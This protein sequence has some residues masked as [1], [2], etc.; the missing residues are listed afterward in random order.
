MVCAITDRRFGRV[1]R[2]GTR[3]GRMRM[4]S[5]DPVRKSLRVC[6][7]GMDAGCR[8]SRGEQL[9]MGGGKGL[10]QG[11]VRASVL[12]LGRSGRRRVQGELGNR[13]NARAPTDGE[14]QSVG[15]DWRARLESASLSK[16]GPKSFSLTV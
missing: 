10:Q 13:S 2:G 8:T 7:P 3:P 12:R 4:A 14:A 6:R 9:E 5:G 16:S 15:G 1:Y 11:V